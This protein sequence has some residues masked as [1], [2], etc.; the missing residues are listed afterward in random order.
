MRREAQ[1]I[2]PPPLCANTGLSKHAFLVL[3]PEP[4]PCLRKRGGGGDTCFRWER[5]WVELAY[6]EL[7]ENVCL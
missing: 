3:E 2:V 7:E 1:K 4:G 5:I 6:L